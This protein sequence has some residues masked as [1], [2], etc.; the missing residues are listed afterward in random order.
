MAI[1]RS[2][3]LC[4]CAALPILGL[5][6]S[7]S[8][9]QIDVKNLDA[10]IDHFLA[11]DQELTKVGKTVAPDEAR[12]ADALHEVANQTADHLM[13][14]ETMINMFNNVES[15]ADRDRTRPILLGYLR[16]NA[17]YSEKQADRVATISGSSKVPALAEIASKMRDEMHVSVLTLK[18]I[19]ITIQFETTAK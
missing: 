13:A 8:A 10:H 11:Y 6:Q 16:L 4:L 1:L 5:G 3:L 9:P 14:I 17:D 15:K 12:I 7:S 2:V 18:T 19:A